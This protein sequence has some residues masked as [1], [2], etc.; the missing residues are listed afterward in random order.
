MFTSGFTSPFMAFSPYTK[1]VFTPPNTKSKVKEPM[2]ATQQRQGFTLHALGVLKTSVNFIV[3]E[4]KKKSTTKTTKIQQAIEK[5]E[6]KILVIVDYY[7]SCLADTGW[8]SLSSQQKKDHYFTAHAQW[9]KTSPQL[10]PARNS[11]T[12]IGNA[13]RQ[14]EKPAVHGGKKTPANVLLQ[15]F[16]AFRTEIID[17]IER[18]RQYSQ[19]PT[20]KAL[21]E[22]QNVHRRVTFT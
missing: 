14:F 18:L 20:N 16:E 19:N 8:A 1:A 12:G 15:Q 2:P 17:L 9:H 4:V 10:F 13:I 5:L 21:L 11:N 7:I 22:P 6:N 3:T